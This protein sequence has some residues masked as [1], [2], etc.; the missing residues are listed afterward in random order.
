[1]RV[2]LK[3]YDL[4]DTLITRLTRRPVDVFRLLGI[5]EAMVFRSRFLGLIPF[6]IWRR[7]AER[8]ARAHSSREDIRLVDI[9]RLLG[10]VVRHP[11]RVMRREMALEDAVIVPIAPTV[12]QLAAQRHDG[13]PCCV[14]S[15]MYLPQR[16]L[17][18]IVR[19]HVGD[20]PVYVS[21][22]L[23]ITK[24]SGRLFQHVAAA[25]GISLSRM[26]HCGDNPVTDHAVP[27]R[28]GMNAT[29]IPVSAGGIPAGALDTLKCPQKEDPFFEMGFRVA[30]PTAFVM[31]MYLAERVA[32]EKP[33]RLIFG[34]RDMHLILYAFER[35]SDYTS[36]HYCRISRSA[37]YRAQFHATGNPERLFEGGDTGRTF[38]ARLGAP[39]PP[40]LADLSPIQQYRRFL[41]AVRE[42]DFALGCEREFELVRDYL[43]HEGFQSGAWF[44]DLGWRGSIQ[45]A[46]NEILKP[47]RPILGC[48]LGTLT[49]HPLRHGLYFD[50]GRPYRRM[51]RVIQAISFM[52]LVFME[53]VPSLA[54]IAHADEGEGF[55]FVFTDD[56]STEQQAARLRIAAGARAFL[57]MM[58]PVHK[59][60][61]FRM[62]RLLRE[63]DS[64]YDRYL[65]APPGH[66][67][68]ALESTT[69][70]GG[71]GG[72]GKRLLVGD[73]TGTPLGLLRSEW[74]GG[75]LVKHENSR[76]LPALRS[77]HNPLAYTGYVWLKRQ[78]HRYRA[79]RRQQ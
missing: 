29:L 37:V 62:D 54:R 28:L 6:H 36:T 23:G 52:E 65:L 38:F 14:I 48:Y 46:I 24:G 4:F 56:E 53:A 19:R 61:P 31:A 42:K 63:L 13:A 51:F 76:W 26:H 70:S 8:L 74:Q 60:V 22:E 69:H 1:M 58:I 34:A 32:R 55:K 79:M 16:F 27:L 35:L 75:Y 43:R 25:Y 67:I 77:V 33:P 7:W 12:A 10:W 9:Y 73:D 59:T 41:S 21:S 64:L 78:V 47:E 40:E 68:S 30:G 11:A 45:Q 17:K 50:G 72:T 66:W 57:D 71:F 39:C 49:P 2:Y 3:S 44:V 5:S 20:V 18:K 15:D